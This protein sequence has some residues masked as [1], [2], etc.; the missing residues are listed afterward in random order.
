MDIDKEIAD[1]KRRVGDLEGAVNVLTGQLS[2]VH[3]TLRM[4]GET[5]GARFDRTDDSLDLL[6]K[7]LERLDTHVWSLRDDL[8]DMIREALAEGGRGP[9]GN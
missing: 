4:L 5:T 3:P 8:P 6:T 1:L 2:Q 7:R 9:T